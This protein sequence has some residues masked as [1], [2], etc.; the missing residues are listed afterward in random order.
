M[1]KT[2]MVKKGHANGINGNVGVAAY[3]IVEGKG[4]VGNAIIRARIVVTLARGRTDVPGEIV[5]RGRNYVQG[6][7]S[8]HKCIKK[9][10]TMYSH[11]FHKFITQ[12]P[13]REQ[14]DSD[15]VV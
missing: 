14:R 11:A 3:M 5:E 9:I 7:P 13:T 2:A 6:C 8:Q 1:T 10:C 12:I 4:G 15:L